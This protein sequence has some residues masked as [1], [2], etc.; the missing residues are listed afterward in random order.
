M[1][2]LVQ[3]H[4]PTVDRLAAAFPVVLMTAGSAA[5][6]TAIPVGILWLAGRVTDDPAHHLLIS[7][8]AVPVAMV[9]WA[10]ALFWLD[11]LYMRVA[12]AREPVDL[13]AAEDEDPEE[14]RWLRGPLEPL[15]VGTLIVA[16]VAML[17]W[18]FVLAENPGAWLS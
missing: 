14:E 9:I 17:F 10:R 1:I 5:L 3:A 2:G 15:L 8:P 12:M 16:L 7:L 11:R 18:F 13:E 6:W 4:S